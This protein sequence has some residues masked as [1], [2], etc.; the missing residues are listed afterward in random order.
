MTK[1][2]TIHD[3]FISLI[4]IT[5]KSLMPLMLVTSLLHLYHNVNSIVRWNLIPKAQKP[6]LGGKLN[7]FRYYTEDH[8]TNILLQHFQQNRNIISSQ[9]RSELLHYNH[10]LLWAF[11]RKGCFRFIAGWLFCCTFLR[12]VPSWK[13]NKISVLF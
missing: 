13:E 12:L 1:N 5:W 9:W 2:C 3:H 6:P 4:C 11:P 7:L 8:F 10:V